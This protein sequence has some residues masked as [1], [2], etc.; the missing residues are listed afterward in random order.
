MAWHIGVGTDKVA[1]YLRR[2]FDSLQTHSNE[3]VDM[4]PSW[5]LDYLIEVDLA[6][7]ILYRAY[8]N[9]GISF[10]FHFVKWV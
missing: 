7:N 6:A 9:Q 4:P 8:N 1:K 5:N 3:L 2:K 10:F